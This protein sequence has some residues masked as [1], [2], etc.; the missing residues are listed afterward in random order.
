MTI[1]KK[2]FKKKKI[3]KIGLPIPIECNI[4]E[5]DLKNNKLFIKN[6]HKHKWGNETPKSILCFLP[7]SKSFLA[8]GMS[9]IINLCLNLGKKWNAKI[10]LCP[11]PSNNLFEKDIDYYK[12]NLK[13]IFKENS[14]EVVLYQDINN[15]KT[16][17]AICSFWI[18]AYPLLKYNNCKEKYYL[19]QDLENTFYPSGSISAMTRFTYDFGFNKLTNSNALAKYM[20]FYDS[21][22]LIFKYQPGINKEIY[23]PNKENIQN[24]II[25]IVAYG[26][27]NND[28]NAFCMLIPVFKSLKEKFKENIEIIT[29]GD[30]FNPEEYGLKNTIKNYGKLNSLESLA[31]LYR[32]C[33][34]G[35]SFITTPTFSYQHLEFMASGLCLVTNKQEGIDDFLFDGKNA[36]VCDPIPNLIVPKIIEIIEDK[37]KRSNIAESGLKYTNELSWEKCYNSIAEYIIDDTKYDNSLSPNNQTS[38]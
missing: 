17:I 30:N 15:I 8:G 35:I 1:F 25:K 21:K 14:F 23:Y 11:F 7:Y 26:R 22:S 12:K 29:V 2:I 10:Y 31:E 28:R 4:S 27:P 19:V 38:N 20:H 32:S 16:D 9:T 18:T 5:E 34:I 33:D 24:K 6:M 37:V 36:V 13:Q 3:K